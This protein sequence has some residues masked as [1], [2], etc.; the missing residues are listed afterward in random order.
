MNTHKIVFLGKS[1]VGKTSIINKYMFD[2]T[3]SDHQPTVGIDFFAH[4]IVKD[5]KQIRLQMWDTAGQE[6]FNALIPSY[7][8]D[9]TISVLVFDISSRESFENLEKWHTLVTNHANPAFVVVG[10]KCD[11]EEQ[12]EVSKE[13]HEKYAQSINAQFIETSAKAPIN[14]PE[15]YDMLASIPL[16]QTAQ[17]IGRAHV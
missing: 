12:R 17:E 6:R 13:E 1:S 3:I 16:P 14:I 5:G 4:T 15:L 9:S 10:N 7:I 8:R 11:L 2:D